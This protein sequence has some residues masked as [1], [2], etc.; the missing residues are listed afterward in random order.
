[1]NSVTE[2]IKS[3]SKRKVSLLLIIIQFIIGFSTIISFT[4][5]YNS[6]HK[7]SNYFEKIAD[8]N[9]TSL[10]Y[11]PIGIE[12]L[13]T[14]KQKPDYINFYKYIQNNNDIKNYGTFSY[15]YKLLNLNNLN[16]INKQSLVNE[17]NNLNPPI[18]KNMNSNTKIDS[19]NVNLLIIDKDL[20]NFIKLPVSKGN[21]FNSKD[22]DKEQSDMRNVL[23]GSLYEKYFKIGDIIT[24]QSNKLEQFKISGFIKNNSYFYD[25]GNRSDLVN[26]SNIIVIPINDEEEADPQIL[27][28]RISRGLLLQLKDTSNFEAASKKINLKAKDLKLSEENTKLKTILK[29]SKDYFIKSN[30][31]QI[32]ISIFFCVFSSIGLVTSLIVTIL[33]KKREIGIRIAYGAS[34]F[35]I[36]NSLLVEITII[37]LISFI[38]AIYEY[39]IENKVSIQL[40]SKQS[41]YLY[42]TDPYTPLDLFSLLQLFIYVILVFIFIS[43]IIFIQLKKLKPKDLIGGMD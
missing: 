28:S 13:S 10:M 43:L 39:L 23:L 22:F 37:S 17:L 38:G 9:K 36:F 11:N 4:I 25:Q 2:A 34:T 33:N 27:E 7:F 12:S 5:F 24:L 32:V 40:I 6:I 42:F 1:M 20:N 8:M 29:N 35:N 19:V 16:Y 30:L 18:D 41:A 26:L 21:A 15:Y 31:S 3:M 14:E